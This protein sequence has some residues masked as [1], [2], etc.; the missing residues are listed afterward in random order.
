MMSNIPSKPAKQA[1]VETKSKGYLWVRY[2]NLGSGPEFCLQVSEPLVLSA[3]LQ[4]VDISAAQL[5]F[6]LACSTL[7]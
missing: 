4:G 5:W 3:V 7:K 1:T 6:S 2:M